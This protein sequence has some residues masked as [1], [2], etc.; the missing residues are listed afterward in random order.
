MKPKF[1][2]AYKFCKELERHPLALVNAIGKVDAEVYGEW[3]RVPVPEDIPQRFIEA[4]D[5]TLGAEAVTRYVSEVK[6]LPRRLQ[7]KLLTL[8]VQ[9]VRTTLLL[10]A[11][12]R[13]VTT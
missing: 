8:L 4:L 9:T 6:P 5:A 12:E 11:Q 2:Y 10:A 13:D 1:A 3:V 7:K